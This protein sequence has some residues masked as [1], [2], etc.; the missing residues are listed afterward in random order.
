MLAQALVFLEMLTKAK[1]GV[2]TG[3][4][5]KVGTKSQTER[6]EWER[7]CLS[8]AENIFEGW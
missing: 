1:H 3:V 8:L 5:P 6:I 2:S 7:E 4:N